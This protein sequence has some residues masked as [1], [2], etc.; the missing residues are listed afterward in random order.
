MSDILRGQDFQRTL[1]R[2]AERKW[3]CR[4]SPT[5]R[6]VF[7]VVIPALH[8]SVHVHRYSTAACVREV[9]K[10]GR[11]RQTQ[12]FPEIPTLFPTTTP[13]PLW[14]AWW[15][16]SW[17]PE[18]SQSLLGRVR[19]RMCV[20]ARRDGFAEQIGRL[21]SNV[22]LHVSGLARFLFSYMSALPRGS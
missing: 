6:R 4:P 12:A 13:P 2:L 11:L 19:R 1:L 18:S 3:A 7:L 5:A 17:P 16:G 22:R 20:W 21:C 15:L 10:A 14:L 8:A 9:N